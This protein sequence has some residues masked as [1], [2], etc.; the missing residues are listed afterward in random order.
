MQGNYKGHL[1]NVGGTVQLVGADK[2]LVSEA[3]YV[4]TVGTLQENLRISE[5]MYNPLGAN[6]G[7]LA[8]DNSLISEDFEY[9]ELVNISDTET[10]DLTGARFSN[11]V[12]FD[13]TSSAVT[14][15]APGERV[16]VVRNAAAFEARYGQQ[17]LDRI[18]G[19]FAANTALR[20]TGERVTL[21]TGDG[22]SLSTSPTATILTKAGRTCGRPGSSLQIVDPR[23]DYQEPTNWRASSEISGSPGTAEA[24]PIWGIV[25]NEVLSR[26]V[27]P[28]TDRIEIFN[29]T[30]DAVSLANYYLSDSAADRDA[31][32]KFALPDV[33]LASQAYLVSRSCSSMPAAAKLGRFCAEW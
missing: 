25:I 8:H 30:G 2:Q 26:S 32:R 18:A 1:P 11:G 20:D 33:S 27:A 7:E 16:L 5:V 21:V 15:L 17:S 6:A 9:I 24:A 13:F 23:G 19:V 3:T 4:G 14:Q 10:L 12:E 28:Q 22:S 31:L 29:P